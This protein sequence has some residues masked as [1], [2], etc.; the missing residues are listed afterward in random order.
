[1]NLADVQSVR[2]PQNLTVRSLLEKY[3]RRH[4][5]ENV[6]KGPFDHQ[7]TGVEKLVKWNDPKNGRVIGGCFFL[8]D[9]MG[10]G[11]TR[12]VIDAAQILFLL[13]K[14]KQ[15]IVICPAAVRDVWYDD[16]TGELQKYLWHGLPGQV[17]EFH[18]KDRG[19]NWEPQINDEPLRWWITNYDFIRSRKQKGSRKR[20]T[21]KVDA[22]LELC[23]KDTLLVLDESAWIKNH[24]S[25]QFKA[26]LKLRK[27]CGR[28]IELNGTPIAH[29]PYDMY[30]Q[31]LI[32][33]PGIL[34]CHSHL[35]FKS[36]YVA[37]EGGHNSVRE[38]R[39]LDDLQERF[40]PY[41]LRREKKDC[42]DLPEK[43]PA[44]SIDVALTPKTW[45][46][47]KE[48]RDQM[49][50]WINENTAAPVQHAVVKLLRLAQL[51]SGFLGGIK[52][53]ESTQ[54]F[55]DSR[56]DWLPEVENFLPNIKTESL[57]L[58]LNSETQEISR[59]K[60]DAL[61]QWFKHRLEEDPNEKLLIWCR[62][63]PELQ[64]IYNE[65]TTRKEFAHVEVGRISGGQKRSERTDAIKL[66]NPKICPAGPVVLLG[67]SKAGGTGL[68]LTAAH[69]VLY[70]SNDYSLF[71]RLQTMDRVHRPWTNT[72]SFIFR[73]SSDWT[74]WT[75]DL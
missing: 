7:F 74:Q 47:Y 2:I 63:R 26:C 64:R 30:S 55:N 23:S 36:R 21:T 72:C 54:N 42:L 24:R 44:I 62:F 56:P 25:Q 75:K 69:T 6:E 10:V 5:I 59:E 65:L 61:L 49:I 19:W 9:E 43:M 48:M 39:D 35:E 14:I 32:M 51:T 17:I 52:S 67:N 57:S 60:L 71:T 73:F 22:L 33:D 4:F 50:A 70:S 12:Q 8:G 27:A 38:W 58:L 29:S 66:L 68:N 11:K 37:L 20:N 40:A 53:I 45:Q 28:V 18:N 15:V 34:N 31:G 13:E 46:L 1:M 41:I 16:E 3:A